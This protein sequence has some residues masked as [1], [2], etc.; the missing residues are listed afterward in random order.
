MNNFAS[1]SAQSTEKRA[2]TIHDNEA[3]LL[4]GLEKFRER[5]GVEFVVA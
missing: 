5:L 1:I 2:V 4:I 3:K